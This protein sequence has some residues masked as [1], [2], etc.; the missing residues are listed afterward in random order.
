MEPI[1][2]H[3]VIEDSTVVYDYLDKLPIEYR[4]QYKG[5]YGRTMSVPRG[6]ASFTINEDIHYNYKVSG[7]SPPNQVMCDTLQSITKRVNNKLGS[8][9]LVVSGVV[10][11]DNIWKY[12][13]TECTYKAIK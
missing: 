2:K 11:W 5:M 9:V 10:G 6:Q 13:W 1:L 3:N 12:I 8:C 7:G 4:K